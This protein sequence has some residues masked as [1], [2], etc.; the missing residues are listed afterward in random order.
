MPR[1]RFVKR[2]NVFH[3]LGFGKWNKLES[4]F[5]DYVKVVWDEFKL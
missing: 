4:L 2:D 1:K 5:D 3:L